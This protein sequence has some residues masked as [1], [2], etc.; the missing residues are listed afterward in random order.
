MNDDKPLFRAD[1]KTLD[2]NDFEKRERIGCGGFGYVYKINHKQTGHFFAAKIS[3]KSISE[4]LEDTEDGISFRRE[5]EIHS[6]LSHPS[7]VKFLGFSPIDFDKDFFPVIVIEY[8]KN[9]SLEQLLRIERAGFDVPFWNDTMR[10]I[11]LYGIAVSMQ[12]LH[13]RNRVH[14]D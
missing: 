13:S 14:R 3:K 1:V 12:F 6:S 9:D 8:L 10:L 5:V 4:N 2:L 7:I 11:N